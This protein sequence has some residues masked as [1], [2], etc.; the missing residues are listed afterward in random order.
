MAYGNVFS[1]YEGIN[2]MVAYTNYKYEEILDMFP[3]EIDIFMSLEIKRM[4]ELNE[5][6]KRRK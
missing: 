4:K 2:T 1:L 3:F 6:M 5:K